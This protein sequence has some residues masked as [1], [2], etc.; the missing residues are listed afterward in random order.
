MVD[1]NNILYVQVSGRRIVIHTENEA[2]IGSLTRQLEILL[3]NFGFERADSNKFVQ[4]NKILLK[5]K[6]CRR[7]Y[8]N[9]ERTKYCPVTRPNIKKFF[10]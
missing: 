1:K 8:F 2:Y 7:V 4:I 5:D 9:A 6:K 10:W 3:K